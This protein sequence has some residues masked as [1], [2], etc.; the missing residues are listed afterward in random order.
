MYGPPDPDTMV[1]WQRPVYGSC[2]SCLITTASVVSNQLSASHLTHR[3]VHTILGVHVE[4]GLLNLNSKSR[5]RCIAW[6][7]VRII[8]REV[9]CWWV[10]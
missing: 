4:D 7:E 1:V 10:K 3:E 5:R 9:R 6:N 2:N 8:P